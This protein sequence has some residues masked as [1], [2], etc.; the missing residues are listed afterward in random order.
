MANF[1]IVPQNELLA[2]HIKILDPFRDDPVKPPESKSD[3][4]NTQVSYQDTPADPV[5]LDP[6]SYCKCDNCVKQNTKEESFCC[7]DTKYLRI[8]GNSLSLYFS[9]KFIQ[10]ESCILENPDIPGVLNKKVLMINLR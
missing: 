2:E 8:S 6:A 4:D 1:E 7:K 9:I 3:E 10:I 5:D